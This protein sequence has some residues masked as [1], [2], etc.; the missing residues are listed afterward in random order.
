MMKTYVPDDLLW[1]INQ[2]IKS[3]DASPGSEFSPVWR[4]EILNRCR[5]VVEGVVE[6]RD[7]AD[8]FAKT[9]AALA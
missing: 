2:K 9:D 3:L 4:E 1:I 5:E 8:I 6:L 7:A